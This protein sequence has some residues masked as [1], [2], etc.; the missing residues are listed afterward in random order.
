MVSIHKHCASFLSISFPHIANEIELVMF[1]FGRFVSNFKAYQFPF[2]G[3]L[4]NKNLNKTDFE[5]LL[6]V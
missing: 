3:I 5:I 6:K 4:L 2:L 1:D